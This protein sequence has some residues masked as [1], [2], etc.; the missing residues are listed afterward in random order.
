MKIPFVF[1]DIVY[2]FDYMHYYYM[3]YRAVYYICQNIRNRITCMAI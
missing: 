3:N 1:P 2:Y